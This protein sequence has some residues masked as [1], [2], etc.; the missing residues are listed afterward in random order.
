MNYIYKLLTLCLFICCVGQAN[1]Q[2]ATGSTAQ[3]VTPFNFT[4][5]GGSGTAT[6]TTSGTGATNSGSPAGP[7]WG[8]ATGMTFAISSSSNTNCTYYGMQLPGT[9]GDNSE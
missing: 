1:A 5:I 4:G 9:S 2:T 8:G 3:T 7:S 6:I